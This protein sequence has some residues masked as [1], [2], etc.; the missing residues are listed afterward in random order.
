M[1]NRRFITKEYGD[2]EKDLRKKAILLGV[3]TLLLIIVI[4][5]FGVPLLIR[6]ASF[7][8]SLKSDQPEVLQDTIPPLPPK[9][10]FS[11][12]AT[13]SAVLNISGFTEPKAN[14][15]VYLNDQMLT[16][17]SSGES[18]EFIVEKVD[19]QRGKN[20]LFAYATDDAG[21]RSE[22]S[23][24]LEIIFDDEPPVLEIESPSGNQT[25]YDQRL[26]VKGKT[27][28]EAV[29]VTVN[30][31]IVLLEKEGKFSYKIDLAEG[32]NDV[33]IIAQDVAGNKT[34]K[35]FIITYRP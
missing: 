1:N 29:K 30:D 20:N 8:G 28:P 27:D 22:K 13:N 10:S 19:L 25:V 15:E 26:E 16:K 7:L 31:H 18:G 35:T 12:E 23:K 6:L 32:S 11:P 17:T 14:V 34:E 21:N 24:D 4:I 9:F 5:F 33:R 2:Q 3:V